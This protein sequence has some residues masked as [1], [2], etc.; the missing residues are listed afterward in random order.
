MNFICGKMVATGRYRSH[1][2]KPNS[3]LPKTTQEVVKIG[4]AGKKKHTIGKNRQKIGEHRS[5]LFFWWL[6]Q[7]I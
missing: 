3:K 7:P 1:V 5:F 6:N 2:V 4:E